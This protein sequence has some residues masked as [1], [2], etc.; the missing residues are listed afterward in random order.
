M[1]LFLSMMTFSF[2][3]SET[4]APGKINGKSQY[5]NKLKIINLNEAVMKQNL[6]NSEMSIFISFHQSNRTA[7]VKFKGLQLFPCQWLP[8]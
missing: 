2:V 1:E 3:R 7:L 5:K 8:C 6:S 4:Q